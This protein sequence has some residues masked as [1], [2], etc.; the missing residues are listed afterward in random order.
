[1]NKV[2]YKDKDRIEDGEPYNVK[3]GDDFETEFRDYTKK[4]FENMS[5]YI[6]S[7]FE[8]NKLDFEE[9]YKK[10]LIKREKNTEEYFYINVKLNLWKKKYYIYSRKN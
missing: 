1:M 5:K 4:I 9:H 3:I 6:I 10:M 7:L 8:I 2:D